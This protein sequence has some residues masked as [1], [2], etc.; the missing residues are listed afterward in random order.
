MIHSPCSLASKIQ[1]GRK[2]DNEKA[3]A[4]GG[5]A[6]GGWTRWGAGAGSPHL[7]R[8]GPLSIRTA[9]PSSNRSHNTPRTDVVSLTR[10]RPLNMEMMAGIWGQ[11][12]LL[13]RCSHFRG[14]APRRGIAVLKSMGAPDAFNGQ[15]VPWEILPTPEASRGLLLVPG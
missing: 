1:I 15:A 7:P 8:H 5:G 3:Q 6:G 13:R 14:S 4:Q 12:S 2:G 9:P 10:P 11:G